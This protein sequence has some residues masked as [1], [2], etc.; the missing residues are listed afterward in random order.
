MI[1]TVPA[2]GGPIAKGWNGSGSPPAGMSHHRPVGAG[3]E[4][5]TPWENWTDV[6]RW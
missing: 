2:G 3:Q 6:W 1:Q 5:G 4:E